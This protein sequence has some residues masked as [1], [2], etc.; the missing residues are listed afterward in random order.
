MF[1]RYFFL[2]GSLNHIAPKGETVLRSSD[3]IVSLS[4]YNDSLYIKYDK[5]LSKDYYAELVI[6]TSGM[7][8]ITNDSS[9]YHSKQIFK[10]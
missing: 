2:N 10:F 9:G 1:V 7:A 3:G 8:L 5:D 6:S 4:I